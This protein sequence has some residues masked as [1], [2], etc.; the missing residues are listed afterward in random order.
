MGTSGSFGGSGGKDAKDLRDSIADWL[1]SPPATPAAPESSGDGPG[2]D[3]LAVVPNVDLRPAL[4]IISGGGRGGDGPGGGGAARGGGS[5]SGGRSGG[6][7]ATRSSSRTSRAAGRAGALARAYAT[8][9][10]AT[11][12]QAG[13]DYGELQ[14]LGSVV[15]I[16]TRIV[17][18]AFDSRADSTIADDESRETIAKVVEWILESPPDQT[19]TPDAIVRRSIELMITDVTLTEVGDTIRAEPSREKRAE[20][21]GEI[22]YAA[23]V[24]ASQVTLNS[25][26][27]SEQ[28]IAAAIQG[29]IEQLVRIFGDAE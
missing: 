28:E 24:H 9:D 25:T 15:A 21:E 5:G 27:P 19:P 26:G 14:E 18:A 20:I 3:Q 29:G 16:G 17:E 2:T 11:L 8:G 13:L 12:E 1:D 23:Q 22:R 4:R 7:G 10:R 6:G